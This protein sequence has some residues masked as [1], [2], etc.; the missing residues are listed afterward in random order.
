MTC[1]GDAPHG[2]ARRA[3]R[4]FS[5]FSVHVLSAGVIVSLRLVRQRASAGGLQA[6]MP[7]LGFEVKD[8]R[9][10]QGDGLRHV[11]SNITID[12]AEFLAMVTG[13]VGEE[14][15]RGDRPGHR[16][17]SCSTTTTPTRSSTCVL[18]AR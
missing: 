14:G 9:E 15:P 3:R 18:D 6:A 4:L 7:P 16:G 1:D 17:A 13:K 12:F 10:A 11:D 2:V 5:V 8:D